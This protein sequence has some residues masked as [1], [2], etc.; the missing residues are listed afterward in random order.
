MRKFFGAAAL[1]VLVAGSMF[2]SASAAGLAT[3]PGLTTVHEL[4]I[5]GSTGDGDGAEMIVT[6]VPFEGDSQL[7]DQQQ[8]VSNDAGASDDP[9]ACQPVRAPVS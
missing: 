4:V 9:C 3:G 1:S 7:V 6:Y 8:D 2:G 5:D